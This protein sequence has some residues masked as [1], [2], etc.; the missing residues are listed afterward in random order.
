MYCQECHKQSPENF[1]TCAYCGAKLAPKKKRQPSVF[2]KKNKK[3]KPIPL[4][5]IIAGLMVFAL[6]LS[7]AAIFTATITG[8]KPERVVKNFVASISA[9]DEK[10]YY[11]LYDDGIKDYKRE[12]RYYGEEETFENMVAPM[13]ESHEFYKENCGEN[14]KLT[15][16]I[17]SYE[18]LSEEDLVEYQK[19]LEEKFSYIKSPSRVDV[20]SVEIYCKG[21]KGEY[22]SIYK[23]FWCMKIKGKW[24]KVDKTVY[25]EYE[26]LNTVA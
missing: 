20:L 6:V 1:E 22:T 14:Y 21:E 12:N 2:E 19:M 18:T 10:L 3:Q 9:Q 5:M 25:T 11:S 26:K 7:I 4:K 8:S 13:H 16:S 23:D 17:K 15:Y 24:Y